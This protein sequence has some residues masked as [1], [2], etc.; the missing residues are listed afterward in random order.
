MGSV[1]TLA[2]LLGDGSYCT[3]GKIA[4]DNY[5]SVQRS[6]RNT[7]HL[8]IEKNCNQ[9]LF[10]FVKEGRLFLGQNLSCFPY[11]GAINIDHRY[12]IELEYF[13]FSV[14]RKSFLQ[15]VKMLFPGDDIVVL[16][17]DLVWLDGDPKGNGQFGAALVTT[18]D[19]KDR[20]FNRLPAVAA[21]LFSPFDTLFYAYV[22]QQLE[23]A[24]GSLLKIEQAC[25]PVSFGY[26]SCRAKVF[27]QAHKRK[28]AEGV[29]IRDHTDRVQKILNRCWKKSSSILEQQEYIKH[30]FYLP[31]VQ[32]LLN[33]LAQGSG[34]RVEVVD[35]EGADEF[36]LP[37]LSIDDKPICNVYESFQRVFFY[38][39][40][41]LSKVWFYIPPMI[42]ASVIK[43]QQAYSRSEQHICIYA[44]T[45]DYLLRF[46]NINTGNITG[47]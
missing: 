11:A 5:G 43:R 41:W 38:G 44:L 26:D 37:V 28:V 39:S 27:D 9:P 2:Q 18:R 46:H 12:L 25:L 7:L 19:A 24:E 45:L 17:E 36:K 13:G 22:A 16:A 8:K 14:E 35:G 30:K 3:E 1:I 42:S 23:A 4:G 15:G 47:E 21:K 10:Y 33:S 34:K 6:D 31:F 20:I 40:H 29:D 32:F